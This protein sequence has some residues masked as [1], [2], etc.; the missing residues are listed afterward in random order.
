MIV[1]AST[2]G[3]F[4]SD[5]IEQRLKEMPSVASVSPSQKV[6]AVYNN[7]G[8]VVRVEAITNLVVEAE[9]AEVGFNLFGRF[10][11]I[12]RRS[13]GPNQVNHFLADQLHIRHDIPYDPLFTADSHLRYVDSGSVGKGF[14][15]EVLAGS[16]YDTSNI[17]H[18]R[19]PNAFAEELVYVTVK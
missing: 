14:N 16:K 10:F 12:H 13:V 15:L 17:G 18:A 2:T 4:L 19:T 3:T 9:K 8:Y 11:G 6:N 5:M 1:N 7:S